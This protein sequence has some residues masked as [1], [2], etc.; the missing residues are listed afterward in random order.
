LEYNLDISIV[1]TFLKLGTT[2]QFLHFRTGEQL[3]L[4]V[5]HLAKRLDRYWQTFDQL[6]P[7]LSLNHLQTLSSASLKLLDHRGELL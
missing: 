2:K 5:L 7:H 4:F 1:L 3:V 6:L